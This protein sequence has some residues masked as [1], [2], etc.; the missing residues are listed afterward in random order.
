MPPAE[1]RLPNSSARKPAVTGGSYFSLHFGGRSGA[2]LACPDLSRP[3]REILGA[4]V[5][6]HAANSAESVWLQFT[7]LAPRDF[8]EGSDEGSLRNSGP[9]RAFCV[10][11]SSCRRGPRGGILV[12]FFRRSPVDFDRTLEVRAVFDH[13]LRRRQIPDHGTVFLDLDPSLRAHV[14]LHVAVHHYVA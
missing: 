11:N 8:C 12:G 13:D 14:S 2:C 6:S 3:G 10:M 4:L 1:F 9:S 7:L 5:G